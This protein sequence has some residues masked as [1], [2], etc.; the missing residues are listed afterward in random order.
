MVAN[1]TFGFLKAAVLFATVTAAGGS[2]AGYDIASM[3]TYVWL[4]QG[5]I[6]AM[7]LNGAA[8]IGERIRSGDVAVDFA[9]PLDVQT[10]YLATDLG[11]NLFVLPTRTLPM[12][13]IGLLTTGMS[14]A[15]AFWPYPVAAVAIVLGM[16]LSFC[17]RYAVNV[18]GFWLVEGRG[19]RWFYML[20]STFLSGLFVPVPLFPDW[21]R[22]VANATPFPSILQTPIDLLAGR[23]DG[24]AA[25]QAV[26]V[27]LFWVVVT[28][29][30]G[31]LLTR[32]GR[33]KLEVQGG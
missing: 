13:V 26:V 14:F 5:L 17:C 29:A 2:L 20:V 9:R 33:L 21:L 11:R 30:V 28:F 22:A 23:L 32:R 12:I 24:G 10:S 4:S 7:Q 6:G 27:Q 3:A 8:D 19:L 31:S 25:V 1:V 18:V 15:P 16:T